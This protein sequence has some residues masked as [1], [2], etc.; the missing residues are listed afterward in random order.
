[1]AT[2]KHD[3]RY[4]GHLHRWEAASRYCYRNG[5]D[6]R[7]SV[8]FGMGYRFQAQ[9][10][11]LFESFVRLPEVCSSE[12][13]YPHGKS[14]YMMSSDDNTD[15]YAGIG[16]K[17]CR[18]K[19]FRLLRRGDGLRRKG[20]QC[21]VGYICGLCLEENLHSQADRIFEAAAESNDYGQRPL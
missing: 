7:C 13:K 11:G 19:L 20:S 12:A 2:E 14:V 4:Q 16:V 8:C 9:A 17:P 15:H 5:W 21:F 1:M 18:P 10:S 6:I 3:W